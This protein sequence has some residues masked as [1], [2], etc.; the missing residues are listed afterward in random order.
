MSRLL[1]NENPLQV[2]PTLACAIGLNEA[3][4]LQQIHYW[5]NSSRHT[6]DARRWVYNSVTNWQ[7]QFPFWSE[8]TVK[9]A[10][11]S[12]EKQGM[13][14]SANYN[15]DPRD[16]SKWYSIN[17][18][19]LEA[20][21]QQQKRVNDALG[22]IDPMEQVNVT[23]CNEP[24]CTN[25]Q[26]QI[27][28]MRQVNM[29]QPLP[30]T[31]T[32]NTQEITPEI[33]TPGAQADAGTPTKPKKQVSEYSDEFEHAWSEYPRREGSNPK[34]KAYQAW[35][36]RIREGVRV[37]AMLAGLRR[38]AEFCKAKGQVGTGFVMQAARFFGPGREFETDWKVSTPQSG[39]GGNRPPIGNFESQDYGESNYNW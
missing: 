3:V 2:L 19:A 27:E 34:N 5:M 28:P 11:L 29:T 38:Y 22:Q 26:G 10:L 18:D 30:E 37:D 21:E 24:T 1:I 15:R 33:K 8:S 12:L 31:T 17:Y 16:Q 39:F 20:L 13:V 36:A 9:R 35:G 32:E 6:Y 14:S 25:A 4:V 23:Q 7:K